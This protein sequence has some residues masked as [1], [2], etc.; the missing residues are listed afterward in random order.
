[1]IILTMS[2]WDT[3]TDLHCTPSTS[4]LGGGRGDPVKIKMSIGAA[5]TGIVA[6]TVFVAVSIALT[7]PS[8]LLTTYA[9]ALSDV[10]AMIKGLPPTVT[11][12]V[13]VSVAVVMTLTV[14]SPVFETNTDVPE[15]FVLKNCGPLPTG[16][17][18]D[19]VSVA[20]SITLTVA[21]EPLVT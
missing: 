11:V 5:P 14:P 10:N 13:T 20:I 7:V 9:N 8:K 3:K 19:T 18:A 12:A 6:I 2:V 4:T 15:G 16:I 21:S 17:V 1:M